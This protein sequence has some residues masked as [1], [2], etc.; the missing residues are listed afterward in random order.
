MREKEC[1]LAFI[2]PFNKGG[3]FKGIIMREKECL[4]A[5]ISPFFKGGLRGLI[6]Q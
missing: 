6:G 5:F 2:S 1:L 3:D 4:L